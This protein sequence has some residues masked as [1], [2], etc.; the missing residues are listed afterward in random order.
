MV[1]AF[2]PNL[3]GTFYHVCESLFEDFGLKRADFTMAYATLSFAVDIEDI[4]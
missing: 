4:A 1:I 2:S 3:L